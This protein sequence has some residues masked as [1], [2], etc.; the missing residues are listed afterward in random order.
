MDFQQFLRERNTAL[1][2]LDRTRLEAYMRHY[3]VTIP[4]DDEVFWRGVHKARTAVPTFPEWVRAES[5]AW[6]RA[7]NSAP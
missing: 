3:N 5:R 1:L 2:S 7:H 4:D 6:L